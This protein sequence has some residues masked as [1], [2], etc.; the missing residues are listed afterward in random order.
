MIQADAPRPHALLVDWGTS[1]LRAWAWQGNELVSEAV[2]DPRGMK[3]LA[4]TE[5]PSVVAEIREALGADADVPVL[6]CGMAGARGGWR[7]A[8][9]LSAPV[10][11]SHLAPNLFVFR[12]E[13]SDIRIVPGVRLLKQRADVMRGEETQLFGLLQSGAHTRVCLPGTH[14]KWASLAQG[15]LEDFS[16]FMTGEIFEVLSK[17]SILSQTLGADW[18]WDDFRAGVAEAVR[19]P[20]EV[21]RSLF[22]LR[23]GTLLNEGP[24]SGRARLSGL[25]IGAECSAARSAFD[26]GPVTLIADGEMAQAYRHALDVAGFAV[27]LMDGET[28]TRQGLTR[29]AQEIWK[30]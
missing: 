20:E 22:G 10:D 14:C 25:L 27:T 17:H 21:W 11:L 9:Y 4:S 28:A 3:F 16:T 18:G 5:Y 29:L 30:H 23:A 13:S 7:E 24:A 26:A 2:T 1:K 12:H 15:R 19:S 6:I 8:S